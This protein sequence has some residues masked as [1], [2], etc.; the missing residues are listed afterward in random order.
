MK[1][2]KL[3]HVTLP[4]GFVLAKCEKEQHLNFVDT[5]SVDRR[6][7]WEFNFTEQEIKDYG[8]RFWPF[9]VEVAE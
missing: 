7:P 5:S 2:E 4:N 8:E 9:A 6:E 3:Y 1:A